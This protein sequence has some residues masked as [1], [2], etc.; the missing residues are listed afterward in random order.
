MSSAFLHG[1]ESIWKVLTKDGT[2]KSIAGIDEL[3]TSSIRIKPIKP[4]QSIP[5]LVLG[6]GAEEDMST[7]DIIQTISEIFATKRM[8][9]LNTR[10]KEHSKEASNFLLA[11]LLKNP[12]N[13]R[14]ANTTWNPILKV[15]K[16][17]GIVWLLTHY[18]VIEELNKK[19]E[20]FLMYFTRK[21][22]HTSRKKAPENIRHCWEKPLKET[23]IKDV[24]F[25]NSREEAEYTSAMEQTVHRIRTTN[26][27]KVFIHFNKQYSFYDCKKRHLDRGGHEESEVFLKDIKISYLQG[28]HAIYK[29][30]K[31]VFRKALPNKTLCYLKNKIPVYLDNM[32]ISDHMLCAGVPTLFRK[33]DTL[34]DKNKRKKQIH[35]VILFIFRVYIRHILTKHMKRSF[36]SKERMFFAKPWYTEL[37][38]KFAKD[39]ISSHFE[40]VRELEK[41]SAKEESPAAYRKKDSSG[42]LR[43]LRLKPATKGVKGFRAIFYLPQKET[44]REI[45]KKKSICAILTH[46]INKKSA[47]ALA[48]AEELKRAGVEAPN[49]NYK[50]Y[51]NKFVIDIKSVHKRIE[52]IKTRFITN[53]TEQD[54]KLY[55]L[56]LDVASCFDNISHA[57]IKENK[58]LESSLR[59]QEWRVI[60]WKDILSSNMTQRR[61]SLQNNQETS[62]IDVLLNNDKR[63]YNLRECSY[64]DIITKKE[65]LEYLQDEIYNNHIV[66][67]GKVYRRTKGLSQGNTFS[68]HI[69]TYYLSSL[70]KVVFKDLHRTDAVRYIDD[71]LIVSRDMQELQTVMTRMEDMQSEYGMALNMQ[72][73]KL[74]SS[75]PSDETLCMDG[76]AI[77]CTVPPKNIVMW[78]GICISTDTLSLKYCWSLKSSTYNGSLSF[79]RL[80]NYIKYFIIHIPSSTYFKKDNQFRY[81]NAI[82]FV[83]SIA[84]KI[85]HIANTNGYSS[86]LQEKIC[87]SIEEH[88]YTIQAICNVLGTRKISF[89]FRKYIMLTC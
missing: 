33:K 30:V 23:S 28:V 77:Q 78:C 13:Y 36:S 75:T 8:A 49:T 29:L 40:Y 82:E 7:L 5:P 14:L 68:S 44:W 85:T 53:S 83:R 41:Y 15:L 32:H 27:F 2:D 48:K 76:K 38:A 19:S 54:K 88:L 62:D 71:I 59:Q 74:Y 20:Q 43:M 60:A 70:D 56:K 57:C 16:K 10:H 12:I 86:A 21:F 4:T 9:Y 84:E 80:V 45:W 81:K 47:A 65:V 61:W 58:I 66:H 3:A 6:T 63:K 69:C 31:T 25:N 55:I 73:C 24:F 89:I 37:S 18:Y 22:E 35:S 79:E 11:K 67:K 42:S 64:E 52:Y 87:T 17:T 26:L 51:T 50:R 46:E 39:F 1:F 34:E 72:K